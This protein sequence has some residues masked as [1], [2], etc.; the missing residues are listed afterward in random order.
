MRP[1]TILPDGRT[2]LPSESIGAQMLSVCST[3][4]TTMKSDDSAKCF[5]GQ[6]LYASAQIEYERKVNV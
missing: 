6:T 5:P 1:V 4:A 3:V 2:G